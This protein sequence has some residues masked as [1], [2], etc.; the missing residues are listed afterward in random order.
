MDGLHEMVGAGAPIEIGGKTYFLS[1]LKAKH[2]GEAAKVLIS[3]RQSPMEIAKRHAQSLPAE[4]QRALIELAYK[5]ERDGELIPN[6]EIDRWFRTNEGFVWNFWA[7][8]RQAHPE[9]TI[10]QAE[11]LLTQL[12]AEASAK[13]AKLA[14]ANEALPQGNSS[15]Q[16]Q[17]IQET[18]TNGQCR[19]VVSSAN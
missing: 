17:Q 12:D 7:Q 1:T 4:A 15:G 6:Y 9:I 3:K 2:W 13:A 14:K 5:D 19:G 8:I 16:V 18:E 11:A 10:E